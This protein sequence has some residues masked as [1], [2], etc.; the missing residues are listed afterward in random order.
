MADSY[1]QYQIN[2]ADQ[3]AEALGLIKD[4]PTEKRVIQSAEGKALV[5]I[6]KAVQQDTPV[7]KGDLK[8]S[9]VITPRIT[10]SQIKEIS[11][12]A[13]GMYVGS[14]DQSAHLIEF[15]VRAHKV[16]VQKK[17]SLRSFGRLIGTEA[18]IPE[19]PPNPIMTKAFERN[20][21]RAFNMLGDEIW[22]AL[23]KLANRLGKQAGKGRLSAAG[24]RTLGL[25]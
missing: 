14:T 21:R 18:D 6:L 8:K 4:L 2:G 25:T 5:T 15:G 13:V 17:R 16:E 20:K 22:N 1:F 7:D 23:E 10:K 12:D 19:I 11:N 9:W 3:L 24:R